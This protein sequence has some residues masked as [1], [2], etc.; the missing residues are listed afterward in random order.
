MWRVQAAVVFVLCMRRGDAI[1]RCK[2]MVDVGS[3]GDDEH[4]FHIVSVVLQML[5]FTVSVS[6]CGSQALRSRRTQ[7]FGGRPEDCHPMTPLVLRF[8]KEHQPQEDNAGVRNSP[9]W[10]RQYLGGS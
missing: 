9:G 7:W 2:C 8:G 10:L 4:P 6:I 1:R 5:Q 3:A